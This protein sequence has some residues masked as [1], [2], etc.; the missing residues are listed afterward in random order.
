MMLSDNLQNDLKNAALAREE[1]KVSTLR[2][3]L[4]EIKNEQL[5]RRSA[6]FPKG[7]FSSNDKEIEKG[8]GLPES[9][10]LVLSDEDVISIIQKEA[11]KRKEAA[12]AFRS[13]GREESALKE[14]AELKILEG[15]LPQQV[16][17]EELTNIVEATINE[18]G[19]KGLSDMGKVIGA[20]MG[21][22]KG[23]AEGSLV[24]A[25]VKE[26]LNA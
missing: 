11:K 10:K 16:S 6:E 9:G 20:V 26:K 13:G 14:E 19:A 5:R 23:R 3:L 1:L 18:M 7:E 24:S 21:K 22:L 12:E 4:S 17:I 15:Y 2:L 8:S 25:K